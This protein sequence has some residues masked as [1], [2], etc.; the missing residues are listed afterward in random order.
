MAGGDSSSG[1]NYVAG[2]PF[3]SPTA[4]TDGAVW[5]KVGGSAPVFNPDDF[6]LTNFDKTRK[7]P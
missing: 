7:R 5:K 4:T 2:T 6:V 1:G 3:M